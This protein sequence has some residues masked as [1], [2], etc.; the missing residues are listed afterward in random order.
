MPKRLIHKIIF[1]VNYYIKTRKLRKESKIKIYSKTASLLAQ[2]GYMSLVSK[3]STVLDNVILGDYSYI[4]S[5]SYIE[6]AI[7]GKFCSI[8]S[9]VKINPSEHRLDRITSYPI[10]HLFGVKQNNLNEKVIID[11][12]VLIC[13]DAIILSGVHIYDGAVVGAGAVVTH[14]VPAYAIVGG[15]PA[16]ILR[17]RFSEGAIQKIQNMKWWDWTE[18][19]IT[20]KANYFLSKF[21]E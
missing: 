2:Y 18:E 17:Y 11:N 1:T 19:E 15:V 9:G 21:E 16:R 6:N 20:S 3:G 4:N 13:T 10:E 7:I 14:D 8:S 12:D 5:N